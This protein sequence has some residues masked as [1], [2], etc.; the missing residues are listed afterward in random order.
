MVCKIVGFSILKSTSEIQIQRFKDE[1]SAI[2]ENFPWLTYKTYKL[3]DLILAVWG[4]GDINGLVY[5]QKVTNKFV[6]LTNVGATEIDELELRK[7]LEK[8]ISCQPEFPW[9]GIANLVVISGNVVN[10]TNDW[11]GANKIYSGY[12]GSLLCISTLEP[13]VY[14][15]LDPKDA[16]IDHVAVYA[17]MSSGSYFGDQTLYKNIRTQ[18]PDTTTIY[19][20]NNIKVYQRWSIFPSEDRW[21]CGWQQI[22][23]EWAELI[24]K[25]MTSALG[26]NRNVI[27]LLSGGIDSRVI[28]AIAAKKNYPVTAISYGNSSWQDSVQAKQVAKKL[29][30]PFKLVN[31]GLDYLKIYTKV[32]IDWFGASMCL[33]GVYQMPGLWCL[34]SEFNNYEIITGFTGDPLEGM[35]IESLMAD[36]GGSL[37]ERFFRKMHLWSDDEIEKLIP[38][39]N[40]KECRYQLEVKL[41]N[42]YE[43]MR[44]ADFQRMWLLFQ[45]N[46]VFQFSS[47]QPIMYEY[48]CGVVTPFVRKRLA[49]FTLSLP[50]AVLERRRLF[51]DVIKKSYPEVAK[52]PGTYDHPGP[53]FDFIP[54]KFGIPFLL[55]KSYMFKAAIGYLLPKFLRIGPFREFSPAPNLFA[56]KAIYKYGIESLHPLSDIKIENQN[57]FDQM[58]YIK[59]IN[60][61]LKESLDIRPS[62]KAW[63]LQTLVNRL[64]LKR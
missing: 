41:A 19:L 20:E 13:I 62:M 33:H 29:S 53:I 42:Q 55:S 39:L 57:Y 51:Y 5:S 7:I 46:R 11:T 37:L 28:A 59:F 16:D 17:L 45:W 64:V 49:N 32:W 50:R 15:T 24:D 63:P 23:D 9:E 4:H 22:V 54:S 48:F 14:K 21:S 43:S 2:L 26:E 1:H 25:E 27:L 8:D 30:I 6:F 58:Q 44:G 56:Q 35:Q 47:Y 61:V 18:I 10:I 36:C 34:K 3:P 52:L 40:V 60:S 38:W 31:I 12:S